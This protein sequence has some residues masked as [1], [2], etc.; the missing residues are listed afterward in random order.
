MFTPEVYQV[1]TRW[2]YA[3]LQNGWAIIRQDY[4][5]EAPGHQ[6]MTQ[7]EAEAL[8]AVVL[9]RISTPAS[10]APELDKIDFLR[11]F[12]DVEIA[13]LL[14]AAKTVPAVAVYQYKLSQA[15]VVRLD[16]PDI[17]N[18]L[19]ALEAAGFLGAGRAAK[20]LRNEPPA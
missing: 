15:S 14:E 19:P 1:D 5:P 13:S 9:A 8:V 6:P 3:I 18:G 7:A 10:A 2:A 11:L 20:I 17:L 12:T 16:D 4:H